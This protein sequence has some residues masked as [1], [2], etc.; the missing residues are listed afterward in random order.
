MTRK[1]GCILGGIQLSLFNH[2]PEGAKAMRF[3]YLLLFLSP[4][5]F[6]S[7]RPIWQYMWVIFIALS[8]LI[9][10]IRWKKLNTAKLPK[11]FYF[12]VGALA[13]LVV[14]GALQATMGWSVTP[15]HTIG[16]ALFF[17]S[18]LVW[19]FLIFKSFRR[20]A[21]VP[22]FILMIGLIVTAYCIYGLI[23]YFTGNDSVLWYD[24]WA[25]H[26]TLT[27]TFVNRN[28]FATYAGIGLQCMLAYGLWSYNQRENTDQ[29]FRVATV[30]F[31]SRDF[32]KVGIYILSV[33]VLFSVL[34]L[35]VSRAGITATLV[36]ILF[37]LGA[38]TLTNSSNNIDRKRS[39]KTISIMA[40]SIVI[41]VAF[42][43]LSGELY[44]KRM[45]SLS[46]N[47]MRFLI[48]PLTIEAIKEAPVFG[49]GLGT[50]AE[51]FAQSRTLELPKP[52]ARAHNDILEIIMTSGMLV[53]LAFVL[54]LLFVCVSLFRRALISTE[55]K[56]PLLLVVSVFIQVG[57]HALFDF[58]LQMPAV[59]YLFTSITSA[60]AFLLTKTRP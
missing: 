37:L 1:A 28:S 43:E 51:I 17:F 34:L 7:A 10:T 27:S 30:Q 49:Y 31:L 38:A 24:K 56:T 29:S 8:G 35:T 40:V 5:P 53:G 19:F 13:L 42:F 58:S 36:G 16:T 52:I 48:S 21:D 50:F 12:P 46:E 3:I 45:E 41:F 6:A 26:G 20:R 2:S 55:Y 44:E 59:G 22:K 25:S 15:Q 54:S 11:A 60:S 39:I 18:H 33:L 9:Y 23:V 4:L 57:L 47:Q 32:T 14:W